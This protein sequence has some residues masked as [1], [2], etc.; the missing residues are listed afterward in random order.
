MIRP[1][2]RLMPVPD[3]CPRCGTDIAGDGSECKTCGWT[4]GPNVIGLAT[5]VLVVVAIGVALAAAVAPR[6]VTA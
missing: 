1:L 4:D 3:Y 6:S 2:R 5:V